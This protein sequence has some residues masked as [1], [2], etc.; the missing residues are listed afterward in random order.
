MAITLRTVKGSTL[1]YQ[2]ADENFSSLISSGS[3]NGNTI[4]LHYPISAFSPSPN[5]IEIFLPTSNAFPYTGSALITGSLGITGSVSSTEGFTGSLLGNAS[6]AT[7]ASYVTLAQTAS[8]VNLLAGPNITINQVGTR[9][10]ISGSATTP[11]INLQKTITGNYSISD[12]DN[13]YSIIVA[14][15][16]SPVAITVPSGLMSKIEVGFIQSGSGDVSFAGSGTTIQ[17]PIGLKIKGEF[18]QA[19]LEQDASTNRYFLLGNI[20]A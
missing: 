12:S 5:P 1:S 20:K 9:F 18:Y 13:N 17:N 6:T 3:I 14:T 4:R 7:T 8:Y 11:S 19:Y 10:D 15:A 16:G 2:E